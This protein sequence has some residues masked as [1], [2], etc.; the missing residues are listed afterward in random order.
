MFVPIVLLLS[1]AA[2][3]ERPEPTG[4][5]SIESMHDISNDDVVWVVQFGS[6]KPI[7]KDGTRTE[8]WLMYIVRLRYSSERMPDSLR[9][10]FIQELRLALDD[11]KRWIAAHVLC[12]YLTVGKYTFTMDVDSWAGL[13]MKHGDKG[14]VFIEP[15]QRARIVRFWSEKLDK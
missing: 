6:I 11:E 15:S 8:Q 5:P 1:A 13:D 7:T 10:E 12:V 14:S 4:I 3:S 9:R 2:H